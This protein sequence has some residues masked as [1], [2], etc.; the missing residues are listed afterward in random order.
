MIDWDAFD[1]G[2]LSAFYCTP[3]WRHK[4]KKIF[5]RDK[6]KCQRCLGKWMP[7]GYCVLVKADVVHHKVAVK[8]DHSL[9][10][11]DTNLVSIC[12]R[13]HD[14]IERH[15]KFYEKGNKDKKEALTVE[16]W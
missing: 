4:R 9:A 11:V 15:E 12:N 10:L 5:K 8:D 2:D 1:R 6:G 7:K 13:C 14:E 16:K 3:E